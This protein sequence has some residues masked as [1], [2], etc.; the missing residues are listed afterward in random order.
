MHSS[1]S[2]PHFNKWEATWDSLYCSNQNVD[3][4]IV[5]LFILAA[6]CC[7]MNIKS[8]RAN[9]IRFLHIVNIIYIVISQSSSI[10]SH[11]FVQFV[12]YLDL[13]PMLQCVNAL[14]YQKSL[15]SP[16]DVNLANENG[17]T[18]LHLAAKWSYGM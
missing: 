5:L 12:Y 9:I 18:A 6:K 8:V 13:V 4:L 2:C 10:C 11:S 14:I 7:L 16:L 3:W 15:L 17:D 1:L